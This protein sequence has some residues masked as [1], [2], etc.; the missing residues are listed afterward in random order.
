ML[1]TFDKYL[2]IKFPFR[3]KRYLCKNKA[4]VVSACAW[5]IAITMGLTL[6]LWNQLK[7]AGIL[8]GALLL[9]MFIVTTTLQFASFVIAKRHGQR[10]QEMRM[11]FADYKNI[12]ALA[13]SNGSEKEETQIN[14][15][16][17][18]QTFKSKAAKTITLLTMVYI[19]SWLPQIILNAYFII[20]FNENLFFR[21]IYLFIAFQ[22]LHV[23]INPFI[24]VFRT[25]YIREK[26]F[27]ART[28]IGDSLGT[29]GVTNE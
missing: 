27:R 29:R 11:T 7:I 13:R 18:P 20:T 5:V 21:L 24:Y 19:M 28:D 1:V 3:Y 8:Y 2:G 26:F 4:A 23:C 15:P 22:Q 25:R 6:G 9:I 16:K 12:T 14:N 10:I 17:R